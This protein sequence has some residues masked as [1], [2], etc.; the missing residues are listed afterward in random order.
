[1]KAT[2]ILLNVLP[3]HFV[4]NSCS[5]FFLLFFHINLFAQKQIDSTTLQLYKN[6]IENL[7]GGLKYLKS[8][9]RQETVNHHVYKGE[10]PT[11][12]CLKSSF[13]YL[14][15][16][17]KAD[18][19]NCFS[20]ASTHNALAE[21]YLL[22]PEY[23]DIL[24]M[25]DLSYDKIMS[26][27]NGNKFNFWNL[28]PPYRKLIK[29][30]IIGMQP[31]IRRPTNFKLK[32]KYINNA[33]NVVEDSDDTALA[34]ASMI[35]RKKYK[36]ETSDS[37]NL[38]SKN[39]SSIF[40]QYR[41]IDR[42][43]RHWYN[44]LYGNEKET[45]AFL[46]WLANEHQFKRWNVLKVF[47][48]NAFFFL[49]FSKCYPHPYIPYMPYGSNDVDG[50]VNA[51]VLSTLSLLNEINSDEVTAAVKFIEKKCEKGKYD[52][53]GTYYP[54][55]Y[56]FPYAVSKAYKNGVN[57]LYT[58]TNHLV[59]YLISHQNKDGSWS[60]KRKV[61]KKDIL[62]STVYALNALI[63][64]G[65]FEQNSTNM[66]IESAFNYIQNN[67]ITDE[68]GVHWQGGVFFSGGTV[69]RN[70]LYWKS[71]AYTTAIILT[72]FANYRKYLEQRY[73]IVN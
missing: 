67:S 54:N 41:D 44:Y 1:M 58:S 40:N 21:I 3:K 42:N 35:L 14:G 24:N 13:F 17:G 18:D 10:W 11:N 61:N 52:R 4:M 39:I 25:L 45:G 15:S 46:T 72:A 38:N 63:Y 29:D 8:T 64:I 51:N 48:H 59:E 49:P 30:D 57:Q 20:I 62:Q 26:Y 22:Y 9:Q 5:I 23:A 47:F 60:S 31:Y 32:L 2:Q 53:V 69:V 73:N 50:I 28:H 33:A 70:I 56:H 12:M 55:R 36:K 34:Y 16:K 27:K 71:D 66:A 65:N 37:I 6:I 43:N 19:S 68:F 7:S